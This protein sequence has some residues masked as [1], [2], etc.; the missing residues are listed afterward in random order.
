ME[1][2][3]GFAAV[4]TYPHLALC[5][6]VLRPSPVEYRTVVTRPRSISLVGLVYYYA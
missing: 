4:C 3:R 6:L 2:D 5:F 1:L